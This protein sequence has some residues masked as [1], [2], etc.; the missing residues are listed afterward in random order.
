[1]VGF[2]ANYH[3]QIGTD[4]GPY[5]CF[6]GID[7]LSIER[8]DS[9]V[10]FDPFEEQFDLPA[11]LVIAS[12][13]AGITMGYVGQQNNVLIILLVNQTHTSQRL[14][15]M[16][17]GLLPCQADHLI[18]LQAARGVDGC[19]GFSIELQILPSPDDKAT[20]L[21]VQVIQPLEI[22]ISPIHN[23]D[24]ACQ[25]RDH[26]QDVYIMGLAIGNMDESG[27]VSY[28]HLTLP[29]ILRV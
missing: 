10:L 4:G 12:D 22:Q 14:R 8:F 29:T 18:T 25:N 2:T 6:D 26:I 5:L 1:M 20:A 7:A 13:L 27:A 11:T 3:D 9:Q 21:T 24:T 17:L 28:T 23:V 16:M 19:G 15:V